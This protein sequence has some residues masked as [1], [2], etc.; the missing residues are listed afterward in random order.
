MAGI[1]IDV[2]CFLTESDKLGVLFSQASLIR[3][4]YIFE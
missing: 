3:V 2:E 1:G 4:G